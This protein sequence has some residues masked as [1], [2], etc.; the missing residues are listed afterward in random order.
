M[1]RQASHLASLATPGDFAPGLRSVKADFIAVA[2]RGTLLNTDTRYWIVFR[3]EQNFSL[4]SDIQ[5]TLVQNRR[6]PV[7]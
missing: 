4:L 7:P 1:E 2:P 3:N 5:T 6:P